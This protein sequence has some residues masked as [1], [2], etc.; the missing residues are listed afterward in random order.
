MKASPARALTRARPTPLRQAGT[1]PAH[2]AALCWRRDVEAPKRGRAACPWTVL[3]DAMTEPPASRT[4]RFHTTCRSKSRRSPQRTA[5]C[6]GAL[7]WPIRRKPVRRSCRGAKHSAAGMGLAPI[8]RRQAKRAAPQARRREGLKPNG[9]DGKDGTGRSPKARRRIAP[10][11]PR[12]AGHAAETQPRRT[13]SITAMSILT[14]SIMA[15]NA[16]LAAAGS[17]HAGWKA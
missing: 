9:R 6:G 11:R 1:L 2:L 14:I 10:T 5:H 15:S 7:A 8:P 13:A 16:R 12:P 4:A 17:V 3:R